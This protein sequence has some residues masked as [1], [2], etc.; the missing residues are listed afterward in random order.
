[1]RPLH[2]PSRPVAL[3]VIA[4]LLAG[5]G[6]ALAQTATP[7]AGEPTSES[8]PVSAA[9]P[10]AAEP[11]PAPPAPPPRALPAPPPTPYAPYPPYAPQVW[12]EQPILMRYELRPNSGLAIAGGAVLGGV[13]LIGTVPAALIPS[14]ELLFIPVVGP[15]V[16]MGVN[17]PSR[18]SPLLPYEYFGLA[19]YGLAQVA[20]LSMLIA[21]LST[22]KKVAVYQPPVCLSV[23]LTGPGLALRGQF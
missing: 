23:A 12:A 19:M 9:P 6:P 11:A 13:Y 4:S 1:M 16:V 2:G 8:P 15:F 17:G 10:V 22:K 3:G 21:G 14:A 20:G 18:S 7:P 5:L